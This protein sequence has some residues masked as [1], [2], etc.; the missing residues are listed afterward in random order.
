[1]SDF[2]DLEENCPKC[3]GSKIVTMKV[4]GD[5]DRQV[6]CPDCN[7]TGLVPSI[8]GNELINFISKYIRSGPSRDMLYERMKSI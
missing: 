1:M 7:G 6:Y 3:N 4:F 2:R 8:V 5:K